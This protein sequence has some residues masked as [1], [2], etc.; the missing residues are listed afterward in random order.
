MGII[1]KLKKDKL[2]Y[3][4]GNYSIVYKDYQENYAIKIFKKN[5]SVDPR[6]CISCPN[7]VCFDEIK[8]YELIW[9]LATADAENL[10]ALVPKYYGS[11]QVESI[12]NHE[13]Q[14]ISDSY[15]LNLNYKMELLYGSF[16]KIHQ[17][18]TRTKYKNALNK[19]IINEIPENHRSYFKNCGIYHIHDSSTL[20]DADGNIIKYI[21]FMVGSTDDMGDLQELIPPYNV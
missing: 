21:D 9:G 7:T 1:I 6:F 12:F 3:G 4:E 19:Y 14:E 10:R 20:N 18:I 15:H 5:P 2:N 17:K 16:I 11:C 13:M 8:A